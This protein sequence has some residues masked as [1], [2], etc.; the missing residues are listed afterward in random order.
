LA[1]VLFIPQPEAALLAFIFAG[2]SFGFLRW[3]FHPAKIF[4]GEGGSTFAGFMLGALSIVA[5]GKIATALLVMGIP[6][7][8]VVWVIVRRILFGA[9]PFV[10]DRKHLHF[11]LLDIG[12]SQRKSVAFLWLLS[13]LGG[14]IALSLQ[15]F[16]KLIALIVLSLIMLVIAV[17]V[18]ALYKK[19][20][21]MP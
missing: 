14:V 12:L 19:K 11:R 1:L 13:L 16:G 20:H 5:G 8:D 21:Q 6:V 2:A 18:V 17:T 7:L 3:N 4:L 15:S 9:S 10:G